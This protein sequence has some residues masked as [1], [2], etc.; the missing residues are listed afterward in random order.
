MFFLFLQTVWVLDFFFLL[1]HL[2]SASCFPL[3]KLLVTRFHFSFISYF[4]GSSHFLY[5]YYDNFSFHSIPLFFFFYPHFPF[6]AIYFC[7]LYFFFFYLFFFVTTAFSQSIFL[8]KVLGVLTYGLPLS[9]CSFV[10]VFSF[11]FFC[12]FYFPRLLYFVCVSELRF[13][14][15]CS[16][17]VFSFCHRHSLVQRWLFYL[18]SLFLNFS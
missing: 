17:C 5:F 9:L 8:F 7:L 13:V 11:D 16:A 6:A 14:N 1:S 12:L 15:W 10:W 18:S 2:F 3:T 4:R